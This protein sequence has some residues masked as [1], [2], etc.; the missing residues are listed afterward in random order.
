M[1]VFV[2]GATG[3]IG[4][5]LVSELVSRKYKVSALVRSKEKAAD[6]AQIG[7]Q[8]YVGDL[9]DVQVIEQAMEGA[10]AVFHLAAYDK[11]WPDEEHLYRQV[12]VAGTKTV[13]AAALKS[14]VKRV[15]F[16]S[17]ASVYGPSASAGS[18]VDE[19]TRRRIPFTNNYERSKAEAEKV[20]IAYA[21]KGLH[22][23]IVN[24]TRVYGPGLE[25]DSNGIAKLLRLYLA[26][27]WRFIPGDG[28]SIGNYCF[29][30][31]VVRGH[32]QA[33]EQGRSGES[34]L[35]GGENASYNQL[36]ELFRQVSGKQRTLIHIP[37]WLLLFLSRGFTLV[38]GHTGRKPLITP[39]WARKF[40]LNWSVTSQKAVKELGYTV[41]PLKKGLQKTLQS[42]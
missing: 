35:L 5:S 9:Q 20:A 3:Y 1:N 7:V 40:L 28:H 24:P 13:L 19:T 23:V 38:A 25:T 15:V 10:D 8:L 33:M 11:L 31:D 32:I 17:T 26:G 12:N 18:P 39:E 2:T 29:I 36:F 42:L 14:K 4:H 27:K 41:T 16:T 37:D 30:E 21:E 6:L 34:Y 22:V